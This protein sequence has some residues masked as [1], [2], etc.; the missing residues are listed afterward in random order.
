MYTSFRITIQLEDLSL[1]YLYPKSTKI[2]SRHIALSITHEPCPP[3]RPA[4]PPGMPI[5]QTLPAWQC[6]PA[7]PAD[8]PCLLTVPP[9]PSSS[10][11]T[12]ALRT[13]RILVLLRRLR[14]CWKPLSYLLNTIPNKLCTTA[15][16]LC[17]P[18]NMLCTAPTSYEPA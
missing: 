6:Q 17:Y 18:F 7:Q 16:V 1:L 11:A 2:H 4:T 8:P 15:N 12:T 9:C 5:Q 3:N 14:V 10:A 13:L